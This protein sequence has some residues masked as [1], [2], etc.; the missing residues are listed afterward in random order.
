MLG[1]LKSFLPKSHYWLLGMIILPLASCSSAPTVDYDRMF[2][3]AEQLMLEAQWRKAHTLLRIFLKENPDHPGAHF[4][5]GR[6]YLYLEDDFRPLIAEG[7]LQT[8]L[9]LYNENGEKSYIDRFNSPNYFP[10][11]CNI[12]SAKVS[13]KEYA[14]LVNLN[15]PQRLVQLNVRKARHYVEEAKKI[16]ADSKDVQDYDAYIRELEQSTLSE[17]SLNSLRGRSYYNP[18]Q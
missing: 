3:D 8:A 17:A 2:H 9:A 4:Y 16:S 5:L 6:S 1:R 13:L 10:M 12:E 18:Q 14:F 7:E 11:I 15:A